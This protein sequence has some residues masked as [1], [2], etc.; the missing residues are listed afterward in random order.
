[1]PLGELAP[2]T[3]ES[4]SLSGFFIARSKRAFLFGDINRL[5]YLPLSIS[6][7]VHMDEFRSVLAILT[8][9]AKL[10]AAVWVVVELY[11]KPRKRK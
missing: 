6:T 3:S 8:D 7:G 1:M 11:K 4:R 2:S 10:L 9:T 5:K